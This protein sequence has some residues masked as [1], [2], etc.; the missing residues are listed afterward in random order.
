MRSDKK[1]KFLKMR[2]KQI[3]CLLC[4][5]ALA[6][7]QPASVWATSKSQ[8]QKERDEA[9]KGLNEA[10]AQAAQAEAN[11]DEAQEVVEGLNEELTD[12]LAEMA[13][14]EA[15]MDAK[16]VE[17]AQA[18]ADFDAAKAREQE[19]YESMKKRI[20]YM[21]EKGDTEFLDVLLRVK[22]MS[23]LLNKSQYIENIYSYD[24]E[25]LLEY[26]ETKRQVQ[27]YQVQLD[28][29]MAEM[30][31]MQV[32]YQEHQSNLESTIAKKRTEI[33]NFDAQLAK[34]QANVAAYTRTIA[35]K[36]EQIRKVEEEERK[37]RE[38]EERKRQEAAQKAA[39]SSSSGSSSTTSKSSSTGPG[40]SSSAPKVTKSS[41]GTAAGRAVADYALQFVGNPY[42]Y[43]GTS[44]TNGTDCS[45]F[46]QAVYRNFGYSLPRTSS[47]QRSVGVGVDYSEAQAGD[48]I[49]YAGHVG[50][51]IGNGQI[52]HASNAATG[53]KVSTATYRSIMAVRRVVQ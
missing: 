1:F 29:E 42:V 10:S 23:E 37:K 36:N 17:I 25:K 38:E 47:E 44:L 6:A 50:I 45:G 35:Q 18:Q 24:R 14:L 2:K 7:G 15:D 21:Y 33:A 9:Q 5:G 34:A 20:K 11:R 4:A 13:L 39:Q 32:E 51:Y 41:G 40:V 16:E 46:V 52:V 28:T 27:E 30:E 43:G 31:G 53:I 19:Q 12:L 49:C 8:I 3:L 26:Q 22:S 48:I